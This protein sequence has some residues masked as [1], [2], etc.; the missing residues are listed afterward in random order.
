M[1]C[2]KPFLT[3]PNDLVPEEVITLFRHSEA[4]DWI[5]G[6]DDDESAYGHRRN[7]LVTLWLVA[8]NKYE[9]RYGYQTVAFVTGIGGSIDPLPLEVLKI[10]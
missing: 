10:E 6:E 4:A 2:V 7:L 5:A 1:N 9:L 3:G 8:T